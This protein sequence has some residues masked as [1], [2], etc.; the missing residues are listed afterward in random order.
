MA[1]FSVNSAGT[2][3]CADDGLKT[4]IKYLLHT[5]GQ[6]YYMGTPTAGTIVEG[7]DVGGGVAQITWGWLKDKYYPMSNLTMVDSSAQPTTNPATHSGPVTKE[8]AES[9]TDGGAVLDAQTDEIRFA[10]ETVHA[11]MNKW[12]MVGL[13]VAGLGLI[14]NIA[15]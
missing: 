13:I 15:S 2:F 3:L 5:D 12:M 4:P 14:F 1:K 10:G 6:Y 11:G 9:G 8:Q 7:E